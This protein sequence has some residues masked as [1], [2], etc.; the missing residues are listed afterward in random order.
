MARQ[1]TERTDKAVRAVMLRILRE[2]VNDPTLHWLRSRAKSDNE[3]FAGQLLKDAGYFTDDGRITIPGRDYYRRETANPITTWLKAN[4]FRAFLA[5]LAAAAT[6]GAGI[7]TVLFS[8]R[9]C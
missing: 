2:R 3:L 1:K 5:G 6:L 7:I 4:W 9:P 8:N